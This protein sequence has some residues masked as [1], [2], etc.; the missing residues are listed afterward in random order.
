MTET[1]HD[2]KSAGKSTI[3]QQI[4]F[5]VENEKFSSLLL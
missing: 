3:Q 2:Q 4:K 1:M 5:V